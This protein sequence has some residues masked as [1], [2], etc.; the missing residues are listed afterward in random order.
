MGTPPGTT[1]PPCKQLLELL[2]AGP[3]EKKEDWAALLHYYHS[4][5]NHPTI[6][7]GVILY[8]KQILI[9]SELRA[10]VLKTLYDIH[11]KGNVAGTTVLARA[12]KALWWLGMSSNIARTSESCGGSTFQAKQGA[13]DKTK[14][15]KVD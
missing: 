2:P 10:Q 4:F 8:G 9:P 15:C 11:R 14:H 5:R 6:T 7:D 1:S 13:L 12:A 3:P